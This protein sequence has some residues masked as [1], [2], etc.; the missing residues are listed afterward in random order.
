M[1]KQESDS[2]IAYLQHPQAEI[3]VEWLT[4]KTK[5]EYPA[6]QDG[7]KAAMDI[8]FLAGRRSLVKEIVKLIE[9]GQK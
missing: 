9:E 1:I 2:L 6:T 5:D 8:S 3:L 4:L 7:I